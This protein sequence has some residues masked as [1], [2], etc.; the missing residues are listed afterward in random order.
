[1]LIK[2]PAKRPSIKKILDKEFLKSRIS[3]LFT[4]T[5]QKHELLKEERESLAQIMEIRNPP[6]EEKENITR[7]S[8]V[9]DFTEEK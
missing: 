4:N 6:S 5:L 1:M 9:Q 8:G 7:R 2:D 3:E